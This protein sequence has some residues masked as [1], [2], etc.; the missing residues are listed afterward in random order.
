MANTLSQPRCCK[1]CRSAAQGATEA[2]FSKLWPPQAF[3]TTPLGTTPLSLTSPGSGWQPHYVQGRVRV[4][5]EHRGLLV[6]QL[7]HSQQRRQARLH[8]HTRSISALKG[9]VLCR[10]AVPI[11]S[12]AGQLLPLSATTAAVFSRSREARAAG[13]HCGWQGH[14]PTK[15]RALQLRTAKLQLQL[16]GSGRH[17][18]G[19][20]G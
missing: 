15:Q 3:K 14:P 11:L 7:E 18:P 2:R 4:G 1:H 13:T 9:P 8:A 17:S 19:Q 5:A 16:P 6:S 12:Y 10:G 20:S